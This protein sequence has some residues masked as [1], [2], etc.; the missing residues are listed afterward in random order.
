M[1][2]SVIK[3]FYPKLFLCYSLRN[4][5]QADCSL[6]DQELIH[7]SQVHFCYLLS[8]KSYLCIKKYIFFHKKHRDF[9][10]FFHPSNLC[11]WTKLLSHS[12]WMSSRETDHFKC[13]QKTPNNQSPGIVRTF[14]P[15][16]KKTITDYLLPFA[17]RIPTLCQF[18]PRTF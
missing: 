4:F 12:T 6:T 14:I 9:H 7:I 18:V 10:N 2:V 15:A 5:W 17:L 8:A 13:K 11:L 16:L 1:A 3:V